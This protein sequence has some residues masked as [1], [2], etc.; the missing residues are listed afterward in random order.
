VSVLSVN[1]DT[2]NVWFMGITTGGLEAYCQV[3][4]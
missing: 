1:E 3:S 4:E 2:D